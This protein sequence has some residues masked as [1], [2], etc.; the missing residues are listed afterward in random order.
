MSKNAFKV[1]ISLLLFSIVVIVY[2]I[3]LFLTLNLL[4]YNRNDPKDTP[5]V[6]IEYANSLGI[7]FDAR[8]FLEVVMDLRTNGVNAFPVTPPHNYIASDGLTNEEDKVYPLASISGKTVVHCN[9]SGEYLINKNDEYGFDNPE[10]L[11]NSDSTD[12]VLIGDSFAHGHCVK[13]DE[14]I[15]G[16]L[17]N[18]GKKVLNLGIGANGPLM[19]L[20]TLQEYA[21]PLRSDIVFWFYYEGNDHINLQ[22]EKKSS[23]LMK[24]MDGNYSQDLL[25]KQELIDNLIMEYAEKR[26]SA[27]KSKKNNNEPGFTFSLTQI[28]GLSQIRKRFQALKGCVFPV[29]PLFKVILAEA[30]HRVN[31]WGGQLY[32][33]YIP[34]IDRYLSQSNRCSKYGYSLHKNKI[35]SITK[36]LDIP[37]I[38][39]DKSLASYHDVH[40]LFPFRL[41]FRGHF[42]AKG[43]RLVAEQLLKKI[44]VGEKK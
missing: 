26:I 11:Y 3:E 5:Q 35:L 16:W 31:A 10:G 36:E 13:P 34:A 4:R 12:I 44:Q 1:N 9:E 40:S 25:H 17:R 20:A 23:T 21:K 32:F 42:N 28:A 39:I 18:N 22:E 30:R 24:Y 37:V 43:Y 15:A 6:R 8:S 7:S 29:D 38:D 2:I 41:K 27:I 19:E 14:N 33:V